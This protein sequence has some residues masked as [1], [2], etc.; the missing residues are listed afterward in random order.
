M[1]FLTSDKLTQEQTRR[2]LIDPVN[3]P[4][5][6]SIPSACVIPPSTPY[7]YFG[8]CRIV[9][10]SVPNSFSFASLIQV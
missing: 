6:F 9:E 2:L 8:L 1:V 4:T 3:L 7:I 10:T 5:S